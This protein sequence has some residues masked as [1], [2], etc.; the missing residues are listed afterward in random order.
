MKWSDLNFQFIRPIHSITVLLE[1][2][3]ISGK[4]FEIDINNYILSGSYTERKLLKL[5]H[6]NN[7]EF[8]LKKNNIIVDFYKRKQLIIELINSESKKLKVKIVNNHTLL[9]E[10]AALVEYPGII[11][12]SLKDKTIRIQSLSI[13]IAKKLY[14]DTFQVSRAAFLSKCDL[15]T[16]M[17]FE[18]PNIQGVMGEF[19][20]KHDGE[21]EEVAITQREH[22]YPR[23][24]QD[25]LPSI[26]TSQIVSIADKI[27][28]IITLLI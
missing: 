12:G 20:A 10:C 8:L 16:H 18:Y 25:I 4:I 21:L 14:G 27:D 1:D 26:L 19:Y 22:Y 13:W 7:Y 15:T 5:A 6:A 23:F 24:S 2:K 9:E 3:I 28:N 11:T 17:V